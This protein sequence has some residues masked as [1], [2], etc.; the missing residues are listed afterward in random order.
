MNQEEIVAL[1][2]QQAASL[3]AELPAINQPILDLAQL[4]AD[5]RGRLSKENFESLLRIGGVLYR[6]GA[7][8]FNARQ[9]VASIMQKSADR[10]NDGQG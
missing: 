5:S 8:Q 2:R 6:L 4:L 9:D 7:D 1:F 3:P 10:E